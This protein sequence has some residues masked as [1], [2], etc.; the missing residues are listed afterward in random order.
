M[1]VHID[2]FLPHHGH[3]LTVAV[4]G[5]KDAPADVT[6][7]CL[8]C[9]EVLVSLETD[10]DLGRGYVIYS[11]SEVGYWHNSDSEGE[12]I[13]WGALATA[14]RFTKDEVVALPLPASGGNDAQWVPENLAEEIEGMDGA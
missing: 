1:S 14:T 10:G 9:N 8:E 13:G 7:E 4:Y 6:I 3:N 12:F 2:K 5:E 11:E